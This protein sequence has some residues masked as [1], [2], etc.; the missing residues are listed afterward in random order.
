MSAPLGQ[1]FVEAVVEQ[2]LCGHLIRG[3]PRRAGDS[4]SLPLAPHVGVVAEVAIRPAVPPEDVGPNSLLLGLVASPS[5]R[6]PLLSCRHD[7]F[8]PQITTVSGT[9]WKWGTSREQCNTCKLNNLRGVAQLGSAP[10]LGAGGPRFESGRPDYF[11]DN[12]LRDRTPTLCVVDP[13]NRYHIG[14]IID[15]HRGWIPA[16]GAG[17]PVSGT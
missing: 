6:A 17:R 3:A 9:V 11:N 14:T 13:T 8:S 16:S 7:I 4:E 5:N 1:E 2:D 10:A 15:V 12:D